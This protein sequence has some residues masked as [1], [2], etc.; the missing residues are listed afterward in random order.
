MF[1]MTLYIYYLIRRFRVNVDKILSIDALSDSGFGN[2]CFGDQR[3]SNFG[4]KK[5]RKVLL[6]WL[7][8]KMFVVL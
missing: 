1:N 4:F 6:I 5:A 7:Q 3:L 2:T 8:R